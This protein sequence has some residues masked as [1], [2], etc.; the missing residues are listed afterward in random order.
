[1][2]EEPG[3]AVSAEKTTITGK[4]LLYR[5][6]SAMSSDCKSGVLVPP[7]TS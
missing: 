6:L 1:M 4:L 2:W 7:R 5:K 3:G